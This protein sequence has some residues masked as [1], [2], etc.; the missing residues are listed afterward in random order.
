MLNLTAEQFAQRAFDLNL[1][2]ERQLELVWS[3]CGTRDVPADEF[4][5][6]L[7]RQELLTNYQVERLLRGE[8]GGFFYGDY[9][10]LYL[11]GAGSFARV[12]RAVQTKSGDVFALKVLRRAFSIAFWMAAGTSRETRRSRTV[13]DRLA[14]RD[15]ASPAVQCPTMRSLL[16][17]LRVKISAA[18]SSTISRCLA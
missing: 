9:K 16:T 2:D 1:V 12:Y 3:A 14:P 13:C 5:N 6:L 17:F 15:S 8:K 11:V 7:L 18:S 10:V 4:R